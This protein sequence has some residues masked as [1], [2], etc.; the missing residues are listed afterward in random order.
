MSK[1]Q[2]AIKLL[3]EKFNLTYAITMLII[4]AVLATGTVLGILIW[5]SKADYVIKDLTAK[6]NEDSRFVIALN[7]SDIEKAEGYNIEYEYALYPGVIHKGVSAESSFTI[8]RKRGELKFRVQCV[9]NG[10]VK[11][12][13]E[14][15]T[16]YVRPLELVFSLE[17]ELVA[18]AEKENTYNLILP[19]VYYEK[20]NF[21]AGVVTSFELQDKL[22]SENAFSDSILEKSNRHT[23]VLPKDEKGTFTVRVRAL[24]N[25]SFTAKDPATG[26][27]IIVVQNYPLELYELYEYS[28]WVEISIN[29]S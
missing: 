20:N 19:Y 18:D 3:K 11:P 16:F 10:K 29:I 6:I 15:K 17:P 26:Q 12:F 27:S 1:L 4:V 8:P 13:S 21:E 5:K 9:A 25:T 14:W 28:D 24:N 2:S 22:P 7:W 23:Y